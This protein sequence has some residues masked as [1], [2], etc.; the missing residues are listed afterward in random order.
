MSISV[1]NLTYIY[2]KRSKYAKIA[3]DDISF[4]I[5]QGEIVGL[6]G[7]TGSGKSTLL[8]LLGKLRKPTK[9]KTTYS[10]KGR[11][12]ISIP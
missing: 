11:Y 12:S 9:R 2:D 7:K 8:S 6:M 10:R 1:E 5:D 3:L 4:S